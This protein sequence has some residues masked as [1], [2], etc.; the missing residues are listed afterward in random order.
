MR[1]LVDWTLYSPYGEPRESDRATY[2]PPAKEE[3]EINFEQLSET[4]FEDSFSRTTSMCVEDR[5]ALNATSNSV[6]KLDG[7]N[8]NSP[9]L[10]T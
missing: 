3:L 9:V 7:Q 10:G 1:T 5:I 4:E 2:Y 6:Q 8:S